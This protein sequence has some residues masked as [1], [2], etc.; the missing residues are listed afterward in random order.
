MGQVGSLGRMNKKG[1]VAPVGAPGQGVATGGA[2][3]SR[4]LPQRPT[5][6]IGKRYPT[7]AYTTLIASYPTICILVFSVIPFFLT[8]VSLFSSD[9][10]DFDTLLES[11][12]ISDHSTVRKR[13]VVEAASTDWDRILEVYAYNE[14]SGLDSE[15]SSVSSQGLP[16]KRVDLQFKIKVRDQDKLRE[17]ANSE[18]KAKSF[19]EEFNLLQREDYLRFIKQVEQRIRILPL[20]WGVCYKSTRK[21][22]VSTL[23]DNRPCTPFTSFAQYYFPG[24]IKSDTIA[25]S[26][27]RLFWD[28]HYKTLD[29]PADQR[30]DPDVFQTHE[31]DVLKLFSQ[32]PSW[33]WFTDAYQ[34][35][36]GSSASTSLLLRSQIIIG[37]PFV[38]D[39]KEITSKSEAQKHLNRFYSFLTAYLD[40]VV[41]AVADGNPTPSKSNL[42]RLWLTHIPPNLQVTFGGDGILESKLDEAM[43]KDF[44]YVFMAVMIVLGA[45]WFYTHSFFIATMAIFQLTL[46]Y[47]S[48]TF[49]HI[50]TKDKPL[51]LLTLLSFYVLMTV[52]LNGVMVFFN[53][54]RQSAFMETNG[55]KN[56]LNVPQRLAFCFRKA[57]A[58]VTISHIT[59]GVAFIMNAISPVPAIRDNG[60]FMLWLMLINI[61]MFLTF[62]PC[63]LILHHYHVSRRRRNTQRRKE[64]LLRRRHLV[65][66]PILRQTL[67]AFDLI[68]R[69]TNNVPTMYTAIEEPPLPAPATETDA[70]KLKVM[71]GEAGGRF[72]K[73]QAKLRPKKQK[74]TE[75]IAAEQEATFEQ[76]SGAMTRP[77]RCRRKQPY[78][79]II[80]IPV[81]YTALET[82]IAKSLTLPAQTD[83]FEG[84]V[85]MATYR[86]RYRQHWDEE[87][88]NMH[89]STYLG[90]DL[91]VDPSSQRKL[92]CVKKL[93]MIAQIIAESNDEVRHVT[94]G[95]E[96]DMPEEAARDD[97]ITA[98]EVDP[99][100]VAEGN[101][102]QAGEQD[103][104][105]RN[106]DETFREVPLGNAP[107]VNTKQQNTKTTWWSNLTNCCTLVSDWWTRRGQVKRRFGRFGKR[108]G[109]TREEKDRRIMGKREKHEGYTVLERFFYNVYTPFLGAAYPFI[110]LG[111]ALKLLLFIILVLSQL[112]ASPEAPRLLDYQSTYEKFKEVREQFPIKGSCDY[113]GPFH[114][115]YTDFPAPFGKGNPHGT[116]L[117][118]DKQAY[119]TCGKQ[120]FNQMDTCGICGGGNQCVDCVG[121]QSNCMVH[122]VKTTCESNPCRWSEG[123]CVDQAKPCGAVNTNYTAG[124]VY[125]D[126]GTCYLPGSE[127]T[128]VYVK[129]GTGCGLS[130]VPVKNKC[131]DESA[132]C[133]TK[134]KHGNCNLCFLEGKDNAKKEHF[135]RPLGTPGTAGYKANCNVM[136]TIQTCR[137]ERGTCDPITGECVCHSSYNLGFWAHTPGEEYDPI[138]HK[139][140]DCGVCAEGFIPT[141]IDELK[142]WPDGTQLCSNDCQVGG[143]ASNGTD[144][145]GCKCSTDPTFAPTQDEGRCMCTMCD[146][147]KYE[148]DENTTNTS[149]YSIPRGVESIAGVGLNCTHK[150]RSKCDHGELDHATGECVCDPDFE[151]GLF[152]RWELDCNKRGKKVDGECVCIGCWGGKNCELNSCSNSG[153]CPEL[154]TVSDPR[155][156]ACI[157]VGGVWGGDDCS[158]C[159]ETCREHSHC[160]LPYPLSLKG[161]ADEDVPDKYK[162]C[163]AGTGKRCFGNWGGDKCDICIFPASIP[164]QLIAAGHVSCNNQGEILGCDGVSAT[165]THFKWRDNC[166]VCTN[167]FSTINST[168]YLNN[169]CL[170]CDDGVPADSCGECGGTGN[171]ECE[172]P[173]GDDIEKPLMVEIVAGL[174]PQSGAN[175][176]EDT[177]AYN[178]DGTSTLMSG[179][180]PRAEDFDFRYSQAWLND[181]CNR[182]LNNADGLKYVDQSHRECV[183]YDWTQYLASHVVVVYRDTQLPKMMKECGER[184]QEELYKGG[185][186][187][188]IRLLRFPC[189][190]PW[191]DWILY[192]FV[193][194]KQKSDYIGFTTSDP[195]YLQDVTNPFRVAWV[196]LRFKLPAD[197]QQRNNVRST[198]D[199]WENYMKTVTNID[200]GKAGLLGGPF[201]WSPL[202]IE[203]FTEQ[204]A[205]SGTLYAIGL[206][207]SAFAAIA[208]VFSCSLLLMVLASL[209]GMGIV[210]LTMSYM[211]LA[212]W[213]LG[214]PEQ[215]GLT[216]LVGIAAEYTIHIMEGYLEYIHATQSSLLARETT[217]EAA[218]A[219]ALQRTGVPVA[220]SCST[221]LLASCVILLCEILVYRRIAEIMIMVTLISSFHSLC[222]FPCYLLFLGPVTVLRNWNTRLLWAITVGLC[223]CF[224]L[225]I[226]YLL[227]S[228][229]DPAGDKLF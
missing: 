181:R 3:S 22:G 29:G 41:S 100:P 198:Y 73:L 24:D 146:R 52:S 75:E 225:S 205:R 45:C 152:C 20:F 195:S 131:K 85:D 185:T 159:P 121:Q 190:E 153:I 74:T 133:A 56:T 99:L 19:R 97:T 117:S 145:C 71:F 107:E 92:D 189:M 203:Y 111:Y 208:I 160:P 186:N 43:D 47:F 101:A 82:G 176:K 81:P 57:G 125:D 61:Y 182:M 173:E 110:L 141:D 50:K 2:S 95:I 177:W 94:S 157:C 17:C 69:K 136:C 116:Q 54:F 140:G 37:R 109:E 156:V 211:K 46:T 166:G 11:F 83:T 12:E 49:I 165:D 183:M 158:T 32:N 193:V 130:L 114:R 89:V 25:G 168:G 9:V 213:E 112:E 88:K 18:E 139:S 4:G 42:E 155:S 53:T 170:G 105:N 8:C 115:P 113:C 204:Q 118:S 180:I 91:F 226:L 144:D 219:G 214:P 129:T 218:V 66:P 62:F 154:D 31:E 210:V 126:C 206:G 15:V 171:C 68:S 40:A 48:G 84:A 67:R 200:S 194:K 87:S 127:G 142:T 30:V 28:F 137:Q 38:V 224:T 150:Q 106:N 64:I 188:E 96:W 207:G 148:S 132:M 122:T 35:K 39:G 196:R 120:M 174:K 151:D 7:Y 212:G 227:G 104:S 80:Q 223:V 51:S 65:H 216:F 102:A 201:Q 70:D 187:E 124:W 128:T 55:R 5:P 108:V 123:Y 77:Q 135:P 103:N 175:I 149:T 147:F 163:G 36:D 63:V 172:F 26:P 60:V 98:E 33:N 1:Q 164:Q 192:Q 90:E 191:V 13:D 78:S 199:R 229:K 72:G 16:W 202:W 221:I 10:M 143:N 86:D 34:N 76:F 79:S 59:A 209:S 27:W 134:P 138:L 6:V 197:V 93:P 228:A 58:G 119:E 215:V 14:E 184:C 169:N 217:R 178:E 222:I 162:F 220:V 21:N 44:W 167:M 23:V 161:A 179:S